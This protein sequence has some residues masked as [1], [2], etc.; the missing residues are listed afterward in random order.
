[1]RRLKA[2]PEWL[3][4]LGWWS[5]G[6]V[7]W[8]ENKTNRKPLGQLVGGFARLAVA[9]DPARLVGGFQINMR[10]RFRRRA[11]LGLRRLGTSLFERPLHLAKSR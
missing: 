4:V 8:L 10:E 7:E 9:K 11:S 6:A 2:S 1:M 5:G 3:N